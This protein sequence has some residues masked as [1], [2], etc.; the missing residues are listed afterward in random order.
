MLVGRF[1]EVRKRAK[2]RDTSVKRLFLSSVAVLFLATGAAHAE[3]NALG[4]FVRMYDKAHLAKHPDQL[5]TA[6]KL[7]I[8]KWKEEKY[9]E[10]ALKV[11]VR[12]RNETLHTGG[13]C[14]KGKSGLSCSVECDGGGI[15]V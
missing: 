14:H 6:V 8:R 7:H 2:P 12:G 4:C 9:F 11:K 3:T 5:V 15:N 10:F 13:L 1:I